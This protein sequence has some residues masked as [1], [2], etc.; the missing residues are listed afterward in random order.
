MAEYESKVN[1]IHG[2]THKEVLS[3]AFKSVLF[4]STKM[5]KY[6]LKH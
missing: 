5:H 1:N 6:K 4:S 3:D 2:G